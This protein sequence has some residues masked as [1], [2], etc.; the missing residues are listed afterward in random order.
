MNDELISPGLPQWPDEPAEEAYYGLA[1]D[2]V[3]TIEP[4]TEASNVSLLIQTLV[5]FGNV[6]GRTAFF[7]AETSRHYMNLYV[8]LVGVTAVGRKGSSWAQVKRFFQAVDPDWATKFVKSGLSW[9]EGLIWKVRDPISQHEPIR[10]RGNRATGKYQD[11]EVDSGISDKRLLVVESEFASPLQVM[12]REGNTLSV[13]I[14]Q[15]WDTGDLDTMTKNSPATARGAHVSIVGHITR[16]ELKRELTM[17]EMG[18][19]FANRIAWVCTTR[20]KRLPEGGNLADKEITSLV[21]RLKDSVEFAE[22]AG[23]MKREPSI[24]QLWAQTYYDLTEGR[25]GLLGAVTSRSE[26]QTMRLA[27]IYALLDKSAVV[28]K[29][30]LN[31]AVALWKYCQASAAFIFGT[32]LGDPVAD[33]ILEG[34][35]RA[36][37]GLNRT[38]ISSLFKRHKSTA[39]IAGALT[40]LREH[41]LVKLGPP[42]EDTHGRPEEVWVAVGGTGDPPDISP[43]NSATKHTSAN[44]ANKP[45]KRK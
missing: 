45:A 8:V 24:K 25:R 10:E 36:P 26:A 17:T 39:E 2:V 16:D 19:G 6:I 11:V 42:S 20:S 33:T 37:N 4:H 32:A 34:L 5:G 15:A 23:E 41:G 7:T 44:K 3:P 18:N 30:H 22:T 43:P 21:K 35:R 1:G 12:A 40:V 31:A 38:A 28:R 27:C 13:V 29:E 14:R 9:G